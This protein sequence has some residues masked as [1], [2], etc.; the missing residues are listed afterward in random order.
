MS[1]QMYSLEGVGEAQINIT[2]ASDD[3][4]IVGWS[5]PRIVINADEDDLPQTHWQDNVLVVPHLHDAQVRVPEGASV[6]IERIGGDIEVV[7]VRSIRIGMAAGDTELSRVTEITLGTVAG[8]LEIEQAGQV[9][10]E[11][12]MGDI[13]IHSAGAV[14]VGR[15]NGGAELH[16]VGPVRIEATMGDLEVHEAEGVSLGQ[17]F[18]DVE[19]HNV[20]GDLTIGTVRGDAEVEGVGNVYLEKVSGDLVVRGVRGNVNAV[21]QG[22]VS[23]HGLPAGQSHTV[24]A[25]GDVALGLEPGPVALNIQ[26]HGSI[27]WDRSLGL[28]VQSD[29]RRQL[30]ARLGEGGGEI[31]VNAHGDVVVYPAGEERG[32]RGRGRH[33]WAVAG[34]NEGPRVPPMPPTPPMPPIPP[35]P[36]IPPMAGVSVASGRR[37]APS[38]VEERS[39]ILN[40]LAEGKINAEQAAR[41]LDALGDA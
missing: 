33:G 18:G 15:V 34:A 31:N 9:S 12:V 7:S 11:A 36:P 16:R 5:Q 37:A 39:V 40:M 27:R 28:N 4:T 38:L 23:L 2:D 35:I 41:L 20:G 8:D 25:D 3:I 22:D 29:T 26:A 30:V 17:V 21:V 24:R 14:H 13:E 19:L 6:S 10:I 1:Q 32:R